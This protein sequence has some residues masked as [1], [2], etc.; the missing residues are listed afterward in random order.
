MVVLLTPQHGKIRCAARSARRSQRRFAGGLPGGAI[1][2]AQ[3]HPAKNAAGLWRLDEFRS[4]V[5]LSSLGRDLERFAY[6]A[7]LCELADA[8]LHEPQP[9][10]VPFVALVEALTSALDAA[11]GPA[12][13]R[14]FELRLLD[15]LGLL[16]SLEACGVC[17][18]LELV[19]S[20]PVAFDLERGGRLCS[21][22][23][24]EA[25]LLDANVLDLALTLVDATASAAAA[26]EALVA[27]PVDARRVLRDLTAR[28]IRSHT[29]HPLRSLD[30]FAQIHGRGASSRPRS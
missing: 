7:Y 6:V 1:G 15:A 4:M 22:H 16:P 10:P 19:G 20:G 8:M 2:E 30:F 9:D 24:G 13:L 3:L 26:S 11:P 29:R 18:E 17:G 12:V 14:R 23:A 25:P 27:A 21:A 5:D 28:L